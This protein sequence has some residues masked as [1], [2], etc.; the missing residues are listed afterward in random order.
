MEYIY[1]FL[2]GWGAIWFTKYVLIE[3]SNFALY[4]RAVHHF[5]GISDEQLE[6]RTFWVQSYVMY[7]VMTIAVMP[8]GLWRNGFYFFLK[9]KARLI[10]QDA[11]EDVERLMGEA[12]VRRYGDADSTAEGTTRVILHGGV[13][14]G[15]RI[16][17]K[18]DA[19]VY[20]LS[21]NE[22]RNSHVYRRSPDDSHVFVLDEDAES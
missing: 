13:Y 5:G 3:G 4:L 11:K 7:C 19:D 1:T 6:S 12:F 22:G 14:D 18:D 15:H 20:H 17:V 16:V 9:R 2:V 21:S 10:V 8:V